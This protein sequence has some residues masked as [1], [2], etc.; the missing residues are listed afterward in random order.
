M[1]KFS[2][3]S[4][5]IVGRIVFL[6]ADSKIRLKFVESF[7]QCPM[8][9]SQGAMNWSFF[10]VWVETDSANKTGAIPSTVFIY[11]SVYRS[12]LERFQNALGCS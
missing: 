10:T 3:K 9:V 2:K 6:L 1:E 8:Q 5:R 4:N 12:R 11:N 7:S